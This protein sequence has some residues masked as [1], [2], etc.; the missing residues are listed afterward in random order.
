M[1][2]YFPGVG[3]SWNG[4]SLSS[5]LPL[6]LVVPEP[7]PHLLVVGHVHD[8]HR[9]EGGVAALGE[10]FPGKRKVPYLP[11][12]FRAA[13]F[14]TILPRKQP[15]K[16]HYSFFFSN[17]NGPLSNIPAKCQQFVAFHKPISHFEN[18]DIFFFEIKNDKKGVLEQPLAAQGRLWRQPPAAAG[19]RRW[20]RWRGGRRRREFGRGALD[21]GLKRRREKTS[22]FFARSVSAYMSTIS[23][24][25]LQ[26][27][28]N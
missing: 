28:T 9:A 7:P 22:F 20:R 17:A 24:A 8:V 2:T 3:G 19:C 15:R 23:A 1:H 13:Q 16:G 6:D 27:R 12:Q 4:L 26:V 21:P 25:F 10:R 11:S 14:P 18:Q 5:F